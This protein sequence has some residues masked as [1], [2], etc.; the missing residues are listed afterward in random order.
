MIDC[1]VALGQ[2]SG[3]GLENRGKTERDNVVL[4]KIYAAVR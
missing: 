1:V 2:G 3:A 4:K